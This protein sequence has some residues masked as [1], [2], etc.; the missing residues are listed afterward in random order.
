VKADVPR[1]VTLS[2]VKLGRG[3]DLLVGETVIA[4][5]AP[6][7]LQNTVTQGIVSAVDR[8]LRPSSTVRML[9]LIQTDAAINPGNS[10]GPLFNVLGEQI[11]VNTAIRG[12]AQNVG[13]AI[14]VD[15]VKG[16]LPKL[17][18][19]ETRGRVRLGLTLARESTEKDKPGVIVERVD[20]GSPADKVGIEAG[21]VVTEV[22]GKA[23]HTLVD[24]LVALLAQPTGTKFELRAI[25]PEG[26]TDT[27]RVAILELPAPD[28]AALARTH[29][30]LDVVDLDKATAAR[31]GLR[32][33]A[34]VVVRGVDKDGPAQRVGLQGGDLI[35][36]IGPYGVRQLADLGVL[37]GVGSGAGVALR[38]VRFGKGR[39]LQTEVVLPAR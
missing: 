10:G 4:I 16:L 31:L 39:I 2:P 34:G 5:G 24:T 19:V 33:G 28:G 22:G 37:E 32:A 35:T 1:G 20:D 6:V 29:L 3:D 7:G 9:G 12:D 11:G 15:R 13:F 30:G 17:L 23:T 26:T 27:F 38:V 18:A 14:S 36:R 21:M 25:L 8:E